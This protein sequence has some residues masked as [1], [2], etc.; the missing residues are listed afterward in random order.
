MRGISFQQTIFE[1]PCGFKK[2][3]GKVDDALK[4]ECRERIMKVLGMSYDETGL[5]APFNRTRLELLNIKKYSNRS[6]INAI[7]SVF[8]E[9]GLDQTQIWDNL[10]EIERIKNN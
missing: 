7:E 10:G 4:I 5:C 3:W 9:F 8:E 1:K 2:G 6:S